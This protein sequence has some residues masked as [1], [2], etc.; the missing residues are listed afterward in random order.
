MPQLGIVNTTAL[1][2]NLIQITG[3]V[4]MEQITYILL[5]YF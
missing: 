5:Q 2:L 3:V 4:K 1:L